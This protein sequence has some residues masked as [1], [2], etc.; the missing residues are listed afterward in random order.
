MAEIRAEDLLPSESITLVYHRQG[1]VNCRFDAPQL[2]YTQPQGLAREERA[3][4][5]PDS[6]PKAG[7]KPCSYD[8]A[9]CPFRSC[10]PLGLPLRGHRLRPD[11]P[12]SQQRRLGSGWSAEAQQS[13]PAASP[14]AQ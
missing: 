14:S 5:G 1:Q 4:L 3:Q 6:R 13:G 9:L 12:A 11:L 7:L 8:P 10:R 2:S